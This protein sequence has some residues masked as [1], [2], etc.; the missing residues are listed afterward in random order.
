MGSG[1]GRGR[2]VGIG[3]HNKERKGRRAMYTNACPKKRNKEKEKKVSK[4]VIKKRKSVI[5]GSC[6]VQFLDELRRRWN[7]EKKT[8]KNVITRLTNV[9]WAAYDIAPLHDE[10]DQPTKRNPIP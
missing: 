3:E 7:P 2:E 1:E 8:M 9:G 6:V 5:E 10:H 4:K